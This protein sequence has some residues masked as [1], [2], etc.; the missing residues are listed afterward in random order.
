MKM[1]HSFELRSRVWYV[2]PASVLDRLCCGCVFSQTLFLGGQNQRDTEVMA[3]FWKISRNGMSH[4]VK[5]FEA[6]GM[7]SFLKNA[8]GRFEDYSQR[9]SCFHVE[10]IHRDLP[11]LRGQRED[12]QAEVISVE[13]T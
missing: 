10:G 6:Y 13:S 2:V 5:G 9:S 3:S 1:K 4:G 12:Q 11:D 7:F 8:H